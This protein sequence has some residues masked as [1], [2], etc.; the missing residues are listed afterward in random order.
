[1]VVVVYLYGQCDW[2]VGG[3]MKTILMVQN[4]SSSTIIIP[5][6]PVCTLNSRF[7]IHVTYN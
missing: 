5:N 4:P 2:R 6:T 3:M 7:Y 1:M